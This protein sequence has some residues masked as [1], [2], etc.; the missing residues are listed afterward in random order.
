MDFYVL[1]VMCV[2]KKKTQKL[3]K[4]V[5]AHGFYESY[6]VRKLCKM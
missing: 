1:C 3:K 6:T 5:L 4:K 2:E